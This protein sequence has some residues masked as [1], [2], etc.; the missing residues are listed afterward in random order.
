MQPSVEELENL[1]IVTADNSTH[2]VV[3]EG[4][5]TIDVNDQASLKLHDVYHVPGL[6]KNLV[7]VPQITDFGKYVLFGPSDVKILD[8]VK[9]ISANVL[10]SGKKKGSLFVMTAGEAYV[11][12]TSQTDNAAI[13]HARLGH[14]GYQ[15][16]QQITSKGLVDGIPSLRNVREDVVCQGCQYDTPQ[17]NRVA[18]RKLAHLTSVCLSWLYDKNLPRELWAEAIQCACHVT[19]GYHLGQSSRTKLDPKAR[20]CVFVG[21]DPY[22]KGWRCMDSQTK[23]FTTSRDVVFDEVTTTFPTSKSVILG[24]SSTEFLI[25]EANVSDVDSSMF[26][27]SKSKI[28]LLVLLYVD[29]MIVTGSDEAEIS[30]MRYDLSLRFDMKNLGEVDCFLGLEVEKISQGYVVTQCTYARTLLDRFDMREAKEKAT[31]MEPNLKF[32]KEQRYRNSL[33]FILEKVLNEELKLT[34][35]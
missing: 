26:V 4:V 11:K 28:Q 20:R 3:K 21:Y 13:W 12:K 5:V 9:E 10:F 27:K 1:V 16:L 31:P 14:V 17:Q 2:P 32:K 18:E 33:P 7:S 34:G 24:D 35:L 29:D 30:S 25:P 8:N 19:T 22:R 15:L 23:K 6:S